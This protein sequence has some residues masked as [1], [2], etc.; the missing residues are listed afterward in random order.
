LICIKLCGFYILTV[1]ILSAYPIGSGAW[2]RFLSSNFRRPWVSWGCV[3]LRK[4]LQSITILLLIL[5]ICL[6]RVSQ[7]CKFTKLLILAPDLGIVFGQHLHLEHPSISRAGTLFT[8]FASWLISTDQ[9]LIKSAH[10]FSIEVSLY[11][12]IILTFTKSIL[13]YRLVGRVFSS[14]DSFRGIASLISFLH[15]PCITIHIISQRLILRIGVSRVFW[16]HI[17]TNLDLDFGLGRLLIIVIFALFYVLRN[18]CRIS[19]GGRAFLRRCLIAYFFA[20]SAFDTLVISQN[21][22]IFPW[23]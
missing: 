4:L 16:F 9:R 22:P 15:L 8:L 13:C 18:C 10:P 6:P 3:K 2:G 7:L 20:H 19:R 21:L 1:I 5:F 23:A 12:Y 14:I 11:H 17:L